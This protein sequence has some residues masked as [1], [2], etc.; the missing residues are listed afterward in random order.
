MTTESTIY[1]LC[2]EE[3]GIRRLADDFYRFMDTLEEVAVIRAMHPADLTESIEKFGD[4]LVGWTGGPSLYMAKHGHPRL[5]RRHFPFPIDTSARDQWLLCMQRA[6]EVHPELPA[7]AAEMLFGAF[8]R[9]ADH[10]RNTPDAPESSG[11]L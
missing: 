11:S 10:L 6:L 5:R 8:V 7:E 4:F 1:Q 9:M 3:P 2:G